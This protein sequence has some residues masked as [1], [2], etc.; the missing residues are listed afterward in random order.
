MAITPAKMVTAAAQNSIFALTFF[1]ALVL[2]GSCLPC[3]FTRFLV[4][5]LWLMVHLLSGGTPAPW[6]RGCGVSVLSVI[7]P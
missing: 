5:F 6:F 3:G 4:R 1:N 7:Q 2:F